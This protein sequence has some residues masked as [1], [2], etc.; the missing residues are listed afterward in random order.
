MDD[1]QHTP[2]SDSAPRVKGSVIVAAV[3]V[4]LNFTGFTLILP[5]MPFL[6]GDYVAPDQVGLYVGLIFSV[7]GLCAFFASPVLGALSDRYG[8]RPILIGSLLGGALGYLIFGIGGALWVLFAGRV[9]AGLTAGNISTIYAYVAD[10][11]APAER[12]R[13]Y[14]LLGAIGGAGFMLGPVAGGLLGAISPSAPLFAAA[15][16][17]LGNALWVTVALP[18]SIAPGARHAAWQW[19]QLNPFGQLTHVLRLVPMRVPLAVSFLFFFAAAI[20]YS[21]FSVFLSRV[22]QLGPQ[23]IGW[24][25]F[26]VGVMDIISQGL[27]TRLLLPRFGAERLAGL[28]LTVNA[29]GF[30]MIACLVFVPSIEF[31]FA[32]IIV[33]TLG[34]GLFQPS[35][36][37]IIANAAPPDA[38][39]LVQGANQSQ[40]S[41]SRTLAPLLAGALSPLSI[42]APYWVGALIVATAVGVLSM[43]RRAAPL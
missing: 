1:L 5:V 38:Q 24:T 32:T 20:L 21:N 41:L 16:L 40:Q 17:T 31:M 22:M 25:L 12:G 14:G 4:F 27:L 39:G 11:F 26:A 42:T 28:G 6:V 13:V 19:R 2:A 10:T 35:M 29:I 36:S 15:A 7:F 33:V 43:S 18:E 30:A 9:I 8:R 37:G 3:S 23:G 34:D